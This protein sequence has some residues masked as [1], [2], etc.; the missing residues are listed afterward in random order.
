MQY[1][2]G[3]LSAAQLQVAGWVGSVRRSLQDALELVW[4]PAEEKQEEGEENE[5]QEEEEERE[6][7]GGRFQR[8]MTPLRSFAR[9]SRRSLR[10]FSTRSRQTLQRRAT[11]TRSTQVKSYFLNG[12]D[13]DTDALTDSEPGQQ[14]GGREQTSD[15]DS[16]KHIPDQVPE[17]S[18]QDV[19]STDFQS[20]PALA[21]FPESSTPL[22]DTSAQRSKADVGKRRIRT[23]PS[24][25][26]RAGSTQRESPDWRACDSADGKKASSTQRESDSDEEQPK[27][28]IVCSPPPASQ[29]VPMFPGLNPAAL[30]AQLKRRTGGGGADG[31]EETEEDKGREEKASQRE[32]K[33]PSP[34]Q[35]SHSPRSAAHL[36]GAARVLPP[37]GGTDKGANSS[38]AWLKELKSKK[39]LSQHGSEA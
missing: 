11:G 31:G 4:G 19:D 10:R 2:G 29:R 37:L 24:R 8:A 38:P 20:E 36:A 9:R 13:K 1:L 35:L 16:P 14:N 33:A 32:E 23:R 27:T 5:E 21:S 3:K 7:G 12:E 15:S 30:I 25:S 18:S 34:S 28:K 39:R 26:L 17:V 6:D 22:L